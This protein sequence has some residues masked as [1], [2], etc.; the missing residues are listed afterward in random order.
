MAGF[1]NEAAN[2]GTYDAGTADE[3][4]LHTLVLAHLDGKSFLV[5]LPHPLFGC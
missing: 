3:K 5:P 1:H 2:A 4:N